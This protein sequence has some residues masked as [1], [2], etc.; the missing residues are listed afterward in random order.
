[1]LSAWPRKAAVPLIGPWRWEGRKLNL[2][3]GVYEWFVWP[4]F[5][6]RANANF[7]KLIG[8]GRIVVPKPK[9]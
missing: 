8:R 7:G 6:K 2:R 4:G 9:S 1:M 3:P 5:G